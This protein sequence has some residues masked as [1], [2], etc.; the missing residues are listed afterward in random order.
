MKRIISSRKFF[1]LVLAVLIFALAAFTIGCGGDDSLSVG[2][3][4]SDPL[5]F[6]GEI[7]INGTVAT[8]SQDDTNL[9]GVMDTDELLVCG[10]FDCGSWIM[11]SLYIG[12]ERPTIAQGDTVVMTGQFVNMEGMAVFQ[13]ASMTVGNNIMDRLP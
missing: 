2:Q 8:F 7:N 9:F 5:A 10:R 4:S 11:P 13:V 6:T 3:V 12:S 1:T